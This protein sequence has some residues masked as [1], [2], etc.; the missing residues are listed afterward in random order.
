M[1][2]GSPDPVL[3]GT[4]HDAAGLGLV[5]I[6]ATVEASMD[7]VWAAVT[8]PDRLADWLGSVEGDLREG[9]EYRG[10]WRVSGWEGSGRIQVCDAPHRLVTSAAEADQDGEHRTA[11]VLE[12]SG[13]ATSVLVEEQG[14]PL[15]MVAA[16]GAGTQIHVEDLVAFVTGSPSRNTAERFGVLYPGYQALAVEEA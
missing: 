3:L 7:A 10:R 2:D 9:G 14:M 15:E 5:R 12:R 16:Y 13:S 8:D 11:I 4:L 6:R 1:T